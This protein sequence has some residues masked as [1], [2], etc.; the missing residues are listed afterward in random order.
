MSYALNVN[1]NVLAILEARNIS[2]RQLANKI[3]IPASTLT[4]SLK[5]KK[6]LPVDIAIAVCDEL[7][8]T[9]EDLSY[10]A[11]GDLLS[12]LDT[13]EISREQKT[14]NRYLTINAKEKVDDYVDM[15][16]S[17]EGHSE[18]PTNVVDFTQY[19][20]NH[21]NM[22]VTEETIEYTTSKTLQLHGKVSAGTG[23]A[24]PQENYYDVIEYL[25]NVPKHD[26]ALKVEG[27]SMEPIFEDGEIIFI[28]K[29]PHIEN[30]QIGVVTL[31]GEGY[32]KKIYVENG[33][34]RLV[35]LNKKYKDITTTS[36]DVQIVGKVIM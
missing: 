29:Q 21:Q 33:H 1:K 10:K 24:L 8:F 2:I 32:V 26:L 34:L 20:N 30:G 23:A 14:I 18:E 19:R 17:S 27:N 31:D 25:G 28:R 36:E 6:G 15:V 3:N 13:R 11:I 35:S 16:F 4:A 9:V 22:M 5:S 12:P 7:G